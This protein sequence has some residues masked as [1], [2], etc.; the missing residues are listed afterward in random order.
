MRL[1]RRWYQVQLQLSAS[2]REAIVA[3]LFHWGCA[4]IEEREDGLVAYFPEEVA[5]ETV[6]RRIQQMVSTLP[7]L[8]GQAKWKPCS[9]DWLSVTTIAEQNWQAAW[10]KYFKPIL[11][12]ERL[13]VVPEGDKFVSRPGQIVVVI[14]PGQA[15]GTGTHA[16]TQLVLRALEKWLCPNMRVLDVGTGS[17]ILA[18]TAAKLNA[19]FVAANDIDPVALENARQNVQLNQLLPPIDFFPSSV[20][21]PGKFDLILANLTSQVLLELLSN[22]N[23]WLEGDGRVIA[24]GVLQEEG[25]DFIADLH[26]QGWEVVEQTAEDEWICL[27]IYPKS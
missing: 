25:G 22:F 14:R 10:K 9:K 16:T 21:P 24:S 19:R 18:I 23:S 13:V 15:F 1:S 3:L 27:V 5:I 6:E 12:S 17:G 26:A 7:A 11:I 4:G 2:T 20:R 8:A